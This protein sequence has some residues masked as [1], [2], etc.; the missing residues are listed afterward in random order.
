MASAAPAEGAGVQNTPVLQ[1][2]V[3]FLCFLL[4][5]L[6]QTVQDPNTD[7]NMS[8]PGKSDI[9]QTADASKTAET[10]AKPVGSWLLVHVFENMLVC[11][12]HIAS[13]RAQCSF[14]VAARCRV[15]DAARGVCCCAIR[16]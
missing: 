2:K 5:C 11:A 1:S 3:C 13:C 14:F 6:I 8:P 10:P 15:Y 16:A 9:A 4:F 12:G 7:A